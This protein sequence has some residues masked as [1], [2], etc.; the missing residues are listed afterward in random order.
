MEALEAL[1]PELEAMQEAF[2]DVRGNR[3][4]L[5][6]K[7]WTVKVILS[8][9]SRVPDLEDP[10]LVWN[11]LDNMVYE[12]LEARALLRSNPWEVLR[13]ASRVPTD[14]AFW[15]VA[16]EIQP[17]TLRAWILVGGKPT[18]AVLDVLNA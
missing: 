5:W 1:R 10:G 15:R 12:F 8:N 7:L 6:T 2:L 3:V 4:F 11:T 18:Q 14:E 9:A 17:A 16:C 13:A